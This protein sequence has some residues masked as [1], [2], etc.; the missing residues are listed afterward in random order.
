MTC[1]LCGTS[2]PTDE[3]PLSWSLSLDGGVAKRYCELCTREHLRAMEGKLDQQF[4]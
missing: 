2:A 4:W 1:D 3:P